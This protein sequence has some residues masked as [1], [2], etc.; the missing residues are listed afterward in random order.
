MGRG[1]SRWG[2]GRPGWR[3]KAEHLQRLDVRVLARRGLLRP[4]TFGWSW[5]NTVTGESRG[6]IS[7]RCEAD[8]LVLMYSISGRNVQQTVDIDRTPCNLGGSRPWLRCCRCRARV[9]VLFL[10]GGRFNCRMCGCVSY[11]SQSEDEIDRCWRKQRRLEAQLCDDGS[12]PRGM[13]QMTYD[14]LVLAI[15]SCAERRDVGMFELLRRL[16]ITCR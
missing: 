14:R 16:A 3:P 4:G 15:D 13:H 8:H 7:A 11:Q 6:S 10:V 12:R 5:R 1:G 9:A 2:A